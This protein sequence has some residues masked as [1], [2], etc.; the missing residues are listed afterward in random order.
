MFGRNVI[1]LG[2]SI[3]LQDRFSKNADNAVAKMNS[4]NATAIKLSRSADKMA[5]SGFSAITASAA[6]LYPM[7]HAVRQFADHSHNLQQIRATVGD[8]SEKQFKALDERIQ[9]VGLNSVFTIQE[10]GNATK[11][12]AKQGMPYDLLIKSIGSINDVAQATGSTI[13]GTSGLFSNLL[14][15]FPEFKDRTDKMAS[16]MVMGANKSRASVDSLTESFKYMGTTSRQMGMSLESSTALLMRLADVGL[17]GSIGGTVADNL[18]RYYAKATSENFSTKAQQKG[19]GFLG[20]RPQ[21]FRDEVGNILK[22]DKALELVGSRLRALPDS[23]KEEGLASLSAI[24]GERGK[25]AFATTEQAITL[26]KSM[27]GYE[28]LLRGVDSGYAAAQAKKVTDDIW[29][30]LARLKDAIVVMYIKIVQPLEPALRMITQ[31]ATSLVTVLGKMGSTKIG[32]ILIG[33]GAAGATVLGVWGMFNLV[34]GKG[35]KFLLHYAFGWKGWKNTAVGSINAAAAAMMRLV[36]AQ[37]LSAVAAAAQAQGLTYVGMNARGSMNWRN[38]RG[39]I[40]PWGQGPQA[41]VRTPAMVG[42]FG[43]AGAGVKSN[44]GARILAGIPGISTRTAVGM[45]GG[46]ARALPVIGQWAMGLTLAYSVFD[47]FTSKTREAT[48][49]IEAETRA[50]KS[51]Y[52][53]L[54][55][56]K[57][58]QL[59]PEQAQK[60]LTKPTQ[61]IINLDGKEA[62]NRII[63]QNNNEEAYQLAFGIGD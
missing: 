11:E 49:A 27:T 3:E 26:T 14:S 9:Q 8:L 46:I 20:L 40:L 23:A 15:L 5:S 29:G 17:K 53:E 50:R 13:E 4:M 41:N 48:D 35:L 62:M 32:S 58:W 42:M 12:L 24:F 31:I 51:A 54:S 39:R 19:L 6:M 7:T 37:Q 57:S 45:A 44:W 61:V 47:M 38:A 60:I 2:V 59:A 43:A 25:R 16:I 10:I 1:S 34:L 22:I 63:E 28:Q 52:M 36:H 55:L 21:D 18:L 30:D 56:N 33:I